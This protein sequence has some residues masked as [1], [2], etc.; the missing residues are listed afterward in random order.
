MVTPAPVVQEKPFPTKIVASIILAIVLAAGGWFG[1]RE[2]FAP[3]PIVTYAEINATPYATVTNITST[4]G[5]FKLAVNEET[6]IRVA[7]PAGTFTVEFKGPNGQTAT[8][9]IS[10]LASGAPGSIT[11]S[12]EA[13][14][15]NEIV[16]TSN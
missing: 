16:K 2:F 8:E 10:N 11:H 5:R 12:F 3:P 7:L 4:D 15:A 14:S 9:A 1:Y 13:V 6:P